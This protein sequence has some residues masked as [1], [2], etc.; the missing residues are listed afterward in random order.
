MIDAVLNSYFST[1]GSLFAA[2]LKSGLISLRQNINASS[3]G[4]VNFEHNFTFQL[5][6]ENFVR[7][8]L[9]H[10]KT[11][12]AI[13]LDK[14]SSRLLRNS[15]DVLTTVLTKLFNRS[16]LSSTFPLIFEMRESYGVT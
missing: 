12:K 2:K 4:D 11:N 10:L 3:A 6:H 13:G 14:I 1:V 7:N 16:L 8:E 9:T 15:G 5:V